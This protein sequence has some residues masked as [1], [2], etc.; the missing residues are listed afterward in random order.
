MSYS[1]TL[2]QTTTFTRTH[3]RH[4]AAKVATDLKRMHRLY[5]APSDRWIAD[6]EAEVIE[7]LKE[8]Y[9]VLQSHI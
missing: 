9:L 8:G 7:L 5:G 6:F 4:I 2:T 1:F 3:A